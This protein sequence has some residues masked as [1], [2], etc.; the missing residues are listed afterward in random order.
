MGPECGEEGTG[1]KAEGQTGPW[2]PGHPSPA[3][4]LSS[5]VPV[6]S[7][8]EH[9]RSKHVEWYLE[10]RSW[11][12]TLTL[13]IKK[14]SESEVA[15]SCLTLCNPM[16]HNLPGS[17]VHGVFQARVLEWVAIFFSRGSSPPRDRIRVSWTAGRLYCLS[18]QG[19][20]QLEKSLSKQSIDLA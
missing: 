6:W 11:E 17:S 5:W 8:S 3:S 7:L 18:Y 9:C 14:Q 1:G 16:D 12:Q 20:P 13:F 10:N 2:V 4:A 15:Q 19:S